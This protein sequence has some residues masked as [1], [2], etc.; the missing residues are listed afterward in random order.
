M[1]GWKFAYEPNVW[2][3]ATTPG[4][5]SFGAESSFARVAAF[6]AEPSVRRSV[7]YAARASRPSRD[8]SRSKSPRS[9]FG[10]VNTTCRCATG[11]AIASRSRSPKSVER[12]DW[13]DATELESQARAS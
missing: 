4:T 11:A 3:E 8:R 10:I 7:S 5:A 6:A 2:I 1:C 12:F 13:H 9:A